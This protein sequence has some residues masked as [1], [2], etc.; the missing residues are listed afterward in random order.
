MSWVL[1]Q[2]PG[3]LHSGLL[4]FLEEVLLRK[5]DE[6]YVSFVC[7]F[8]ELRIDMDRIVRVQTNQSIQVRRKCQAHIQCGQGNNMHKLAER[9]RVARNRTRGDAPQGG[10][11]FKKRSLAI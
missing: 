3:C 4:S 11:H 10:A 6:H 2:T 5:A 7:F 9:C 1:F 8:C